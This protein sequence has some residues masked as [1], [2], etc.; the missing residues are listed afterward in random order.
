[1]GLRAQATPLMAS[2]PALWAQSLLTSPTPWPHPTLPKGDSTE[3]WTSWGQG[4]VL[5]SGQGVTEG[6]EGSPGVRKAATAPARWSP[7]HSSS[8]FPPSWPGQPGAP[9]L[10]PPSTFLTPGETLPH[11][12][13]VPQNLRGSA[14]VPGGQAGSGLLHSPLA[15]P[16]GTVAS[17]PW[18]LHSQLNPSKRDR[19]KT[20]LKIES[21][22]IHGREQDELVLVAGR[23]RSLSLLSVT[24]EGCNLVYERMKS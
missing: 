6:G 16:W 13:S 11:P 14:T 9:S 10:W 17:T 22:A 19:L 1:M 23:A 21:R 8:P 2:S 5:R 4:G 15:S 24:W 18:R 20:K 7:S 3:L 12:S